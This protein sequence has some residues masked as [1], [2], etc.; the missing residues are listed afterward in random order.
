[1][2]RTPLKQTSKW[3]YLILW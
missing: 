2:T 3:W 1:V